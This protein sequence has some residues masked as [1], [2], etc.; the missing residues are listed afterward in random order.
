IMY[1]GT[2]GES[3]QMLPDEAQKAFPKPAEQIARI[4][5]GHHGN[6][7]NA[8]RG[9]EPACS[10]FEVASKLTEMLLLGCLAMKA[11]LHKKIEW[12][13]ENTK[14]TNM[15]EINQYIARQYRKGWQV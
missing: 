9:G 5:N 15:P 8:V 11:G 3:T 14:C 12:D 1:S 13:G 4:K 2:Y 10:N 6:F 7:F